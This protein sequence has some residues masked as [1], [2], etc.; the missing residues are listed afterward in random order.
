MIQSQTDDIKRLQQDVS[1][2]TEIIKMIDQGLTTIYQ[3]KSTV[4]KELAVLQSVAARTE[5]ELTATVKTKQQLEANIREWSLAVSSRDEAIQ[6]LMVE[7]NSLENSIKVLE[8]EKTNL[9]AINSAQADEIK[10][11]ETDR[12]IIQEKL[13]QVEHSSEEWKPRLD[14]LQTLYKNEAKR[15]EDLCRKKDEQI[16]EFT[17]NS[18][19]NSIEKQELQVETVESVIESVEA[20]DVNSEKTPEIRNLQD[21]VC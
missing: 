8:A 3:D 2:M 16:A 14:Q 1:Q 13:Q 20:S 4:E 12:G 21:Q 15:S 5:Q 18:Q 17:R 7:K 6:T 9:L 10:K 19:A 11:I